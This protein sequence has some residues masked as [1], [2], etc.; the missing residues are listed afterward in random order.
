[1]IE[2]VKTPHWFDPAKNETPSFQPTRAAS[3][4]RNSTRRIEA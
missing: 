4:W 1:M 2:A 3:G